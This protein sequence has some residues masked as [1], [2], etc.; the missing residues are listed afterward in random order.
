MHFVRNLDDS[1]GDK[2]LCDIDIFIVFWKSKEYYK[3]EYDNI[4]YIK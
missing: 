1:F 3:L 2:G 4:W